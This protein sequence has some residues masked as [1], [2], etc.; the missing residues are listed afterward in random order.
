MADLAVAEAGIARDGRR[1]GLDVDWRVT[2]ITE[3]YTEHG[4]RLAPSLRVLGRPSFP[5]TLDLGY[6]LTA[7]RAA[8]EGAAPAWDVAQE[9]G[10]VWNPWPRLKAGAFAAGLPLRPGVPAPGRV[11]QVG[12]EADSRPPDAAGGPEPFGQVLRLDF[13]RSGDGP[14]R[15]LASLTARPCPGAEF[16]LGLADRPFQ[17]AA[18]LGVAW[19]GFRVRQA[20]RY[21]RYLGR[22]WLSGLAFSAGG[23]T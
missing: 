3:L 13:R 20:A 6:G 9:A 19:R 16:S 8:W 14:W 10:A 18:G 22:T 2:M 23:G 21:H 12:I 7:W 1:A 5:G 15:A 4:F 11:V 17:V